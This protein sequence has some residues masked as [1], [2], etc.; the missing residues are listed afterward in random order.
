MKTTLY[1][2]TIPLFIKSLGNLSKIIDK[3]VIH[4]ENKQL[5]VEELLQSRLAP[6]QYPFI[7][8][9]QLACDQAKSFAPRLNGQ[10]PP[11]IP[12]DDKTMEDLKHHIDATIEILS[13]V[14][15]EDV[16]GKED[17]QNIELPY[18]PLKLSGFTLAF[19]MAVPNFY[20]HLT[21]AYAILRHNGV[22]LGKADYLGQLLIQDTI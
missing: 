19:G 15:P 18:I 14:K 6:D 4:A 21:T 12:D 8:Q 7:K 5:A 2:A 17:V 20:F 22:E 10:T 1:T 3:A 13:A 11:S 9:V 16:E